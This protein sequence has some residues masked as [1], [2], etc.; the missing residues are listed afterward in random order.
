MAAVCSLNL[1]VSKLKNLPEL[2][3]ASLAIIDAVSNPD[4][5]I[6]KLA[7]MIAISPVLT[8]RLLGLANSAYFGYSGQIK[9]LNTAIVRVLGLNLVKSLT[10]AILLNLA[11]DTRRCRHFKSEK[12]WAHALLTATLSHKFSV[13]A[14]DQALQPAFSYTAGLLLNIGLIATVHLFPKETDHILQEAELKG[15]SVSTEMTRLI[16]YNQ[17]EIGGLLL[18]Y[19]HLPVLYQNVLKQFKN[20]HYTGPEATFIA[21]LSLCFKVAKKILANQVQDVPHLIGQLEA[22]GLSASAMEA[23]VLET[24]AQKQ[25]VHLAALAISGKSG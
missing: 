23:I 10:M 2:P 7:Q 20:E 12:L 25:S 15:T 8:A 24:S 6:D 21:F 4:I 3:T 5:A 9:D 16:S 19:W 1:Q 14:Q 11:L 22:L 18:E 13:L 17:Y